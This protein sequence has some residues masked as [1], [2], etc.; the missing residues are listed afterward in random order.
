[1]LVKY[2]GNEFEMEGMPDPGDVMK[3]LYDV[4]PELSHS[5]YYSMNGDIMEIH[6]KLGTKLAYMQ[7]VTKSNSVM[8]ITNE[9]RVVFFK[10]EMNI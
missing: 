3:L 6:C 2:A 10:K 7:R 5:G 9:T 4:F 8:H 1:M